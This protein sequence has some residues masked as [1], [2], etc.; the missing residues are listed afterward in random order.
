[1][2][3]STGAFQTSYTYEPFGNTNTFANPSTNPFQ[4]TGRENDGTG[5]YYYRARY[6]NPVIQRFISEDPSDI[7]GGI[8]LYAYAGNNPI[9]FRDPMGLKSSPGRSGPLAW[10]WLPEGNG[11][12]GHYVLTR[13]SDGPPTDSQKLASLTQAQR[14]GRGPMN[15]LTVV[16]AAETLGIAVVEVAPV[17]ISGYGTVQT[18]AVGIETAYPGATEIVMD[19]LDVLGPN[20]SLGAT[21]IGIVVNLLTNVAPQVYDFVVDHNWRKP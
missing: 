18:A 13:Q 6:Y 14:L 1:L 2:A 3:D 15:V 16:A 17:A 10:V 9:G 19:V 20:P 11:E 5:L 12:P 21:K 8:N 4:Y 7:L